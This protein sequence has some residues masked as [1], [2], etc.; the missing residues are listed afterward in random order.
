MVSF[1]RLAYVNLEIGDLLQVLSPPT[2]LEEESLSEESSIFQPISQSISQSISQAKF[3]SKFQQWRLRDRNG[4]EGILEISDLDDIELLPAL[5]DDEAVSEVCAIQTPPSEQISPILTLQSPLKN[6]Y[7]PQTTSIY[8]NVVPATHG[9]TIQ[10]ILGSGDGTLALQ[11]FSLKKPPLT[12]VGSTSATGNQ[13][14]L[15]VY[16]D[17]VRWSEASSIYPLNNLDQSYTIR[18]DDDGQTSVI[19]GDG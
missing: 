12:Y 5:A 2:Q 6:C 19:F 13:S 9:E 17:G 1:D 11:S 18:I 7:D 10:E 16:I 8:A 15:S 3:Q 4:V 14:T